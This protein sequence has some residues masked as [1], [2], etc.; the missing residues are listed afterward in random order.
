MRCHKYCTSDIAATDGQWWEAVILRLKGEIIQ[1][2]GGDTGNS[3]ASLRPA[4]AIAADQNARLIGPRC[5]TSLGRLLCDQGRRCE[6]QELLMPVYA[7]FTEGF[8]TPDLRVA[9]AI[10]DNLK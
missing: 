3:E 10:L 4:L 6:A 9:K 5:A 8:D 7:R 1:S 2:I